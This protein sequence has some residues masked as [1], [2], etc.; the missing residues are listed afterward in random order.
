MAIKKT[1]ELEVKSSGAVTG[2]NK[3]SDALGKVG[4]SS[5]GVATG[6]KG[7]GVAMKAMGL[8]ILIGLLSAVFE[9]FKKNQKAQDLMA[10]GFDLL[11]RVVGVV[12]DVFMAAL[13]VVDALTFGMFNLAD[14]SDTAS[15]SLQ[16]QRNE[17]RLLQAQ[18]Q[19]ITL[20]FQQQAETQRQI[21]DDE[22]KTIEE[23]KQA[24]IELGNILDNQFKVE[25]ANANKALSVAEQ[26]LKLDE[27]NIELQERVINAKTK[28][29]EINERIT[30][31]RS[32][33]L[34]NINSLNRENRE[35][36][37]TTGGVTT[38]IKEQVKS[39]ED[40][41]SEMET[42]LGLDRTV[43]GITKQIADAHTIR[44]EQIK[45][46]E[47]ELEKL[48]NSEKTYRA[49]KANTLDL[50]K[51]S[52]DITI[53]T[54]DAEKRLSDFKRDLKFG[55]KEQ[56]DRAKINIFSL[57]QTIENLKEERRINNE[58]I[59]QRE[60][61]NI[62][63]NKKRKNRVINHNNELEIQLRE[64]FQ[65]IE[66][67]E[68][69]HNQLIAE[70]RQMAREELDYF[71]GT[72]REKELLD[73]KE[74]F[75]KRMLMVEGDLES[76][77]RLQDWFGQQL[78][79]INK[80]YDDE[81][82]EAYQDQKQR[83]EDEEQ[84]YQDFIRV[85]T[86]SSLDQQL[87]DLKANFEE[88]MIINKNYTEAKL[89]IEKAY[90]RKKQELIDQ[91]AKSE[92]AKNVEDLRKTLGMAAGLYEKGTK[93]WKRLKIAESIISG[94][95]AVIKSLEL[96]FPLNLLQAAVVA[97]ITRQNIKQIQDTEV[98]GNTDQDFSVN[99]GGGLSS[100]SEGLAPNLPTD[101]VEMPEQEPIQAFV[102]ESDVT[103]SQSLQEDLEL[104]A[105]L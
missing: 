63:G 58:A 47:E 17:V 59:A 53:A 61:D 5:K 39:Y 27:H 94:G 105:T 13:S 48:I 4:K 33:Q 11:Q 1:I 102:V 50:D 21:R 75:D 90:L 16:R 29:A 9:A 31:Q 80:R 10:R 98:T 66:D 60:A 84:S 2:L 49:S 52:I 64:H 65:L 35:L 104:Q 89:E 68:H 87:A 83:L 46:E 92:R 30:G 38:A 41:N 42:A 6:F 85:G 26:E 32:E 72:D 55:T 100:I 56:Q 79:E 43:E 8:G 15:A 76:Q 71:L 74:E 37:N 81:E 7:I 96:P 19:L 28:V 14:A 44:A 95:T 88:Q 23:R 62:Q 78:M 97:G 20:E 99:A 101:S 36:R 93:K 24:N 67:N 73:L 51:K 103:S 70:A 82:F 54:L 69:K 22:S 18:E 91:D 12:V 3:T 77:L 57:E 34:V 45:K 40:L 86:M 25:T